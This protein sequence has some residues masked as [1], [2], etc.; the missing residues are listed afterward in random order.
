MEENELV[1]SVDINFSSGNV[2]LTTTEGEGYYVLSE[3]SIKI[4]LGELNIAKDKVL[5]GV[6]R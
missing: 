6:E 2:V 3:N 1:I 4:I 5:G